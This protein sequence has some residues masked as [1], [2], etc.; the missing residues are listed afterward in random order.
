LRNQ[1]SQRLTL[2]FLEEGVTLVINHLAIHLLRCQ[3]LAA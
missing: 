1:G 3:T 2:I